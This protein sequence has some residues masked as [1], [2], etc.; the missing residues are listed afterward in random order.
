MFFNKDKFQLKT[1]ETQAEY[2][3]LLELRKKAY[4]NR[5]NV[6]K[7]TLDFDADIKLFGDEADEKSTNF[8]C[9]VDGKIVAATRIMFGKESSDFQ[10]YDL[11]TNLPPFLK[12]SEEIV[13]YSRSCIDPDYKEEQTHLQ[14]FSPLQ[15]KSLFQEDTKQL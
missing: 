11:F 10:V 2:S 1:V 8:I 5:P 9:L 12:R 7:D 3:E 14:L 13:E 15:E 4:L 6:T